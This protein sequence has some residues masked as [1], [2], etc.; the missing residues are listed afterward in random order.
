MAFA[1]VALLVTLLGVAA[2]DGGG[3]SIYPT[4][5]WK[6]VTKITPANV[7]SEIKAAVDGGKTMFVRL[8]ASE[9]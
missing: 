6:F 5:H 2:A 7:D 3:D 4:D 9:G 1:R 8:I